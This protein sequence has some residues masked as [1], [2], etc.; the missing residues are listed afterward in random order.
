MRPQ[1]ATK[2]KLPILLDT[3]VF[4]TSLGTSHSFKL[5]PRSNDINPGRNTVAAS[6]SITFATSTIHVLEVHAMQVVVTDAIKIDATIRLL[7]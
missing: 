7:L 3:S 1:P 5:M 6:P 4:A 2:R